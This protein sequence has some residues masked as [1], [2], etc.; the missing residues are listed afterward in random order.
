MSILLYIL[1]AY[2]VVLIIYII[3]SWI[4]H[5]QTQWAREQMAP[6]FEPFLEPIRRMMGTVGVGGAQID[7]SPILLFI[8]IEILRRVLIGATM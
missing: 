5:P 3:L 6:L 2:R 1:D 4:Q 8:A 7:F